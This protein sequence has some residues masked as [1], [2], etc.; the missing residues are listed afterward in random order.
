MSSAAPQYDGPKAL[1]EALSALSLVQFAEDGFTRDGPRADVEYRDLG[2][3]RATGGRIGAKHIRAIMPFP[4][5]TGWHWHDMT[6]HIVYVMRGW[7]SFRYE[8]VPDTVT[9]KAGGCLSQPAGVPHNVVGRSDDLELIE[10]NL[11]AAFGT[12]DL[13]HGTAGR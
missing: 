9:V 6:G 11:P 13:P 1:A 5:E 3:A 2:L 7:I 10:I 8:G 12:F 4:Q